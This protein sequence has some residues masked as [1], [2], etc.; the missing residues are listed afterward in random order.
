MGRGHIEKRG[1]GYAVV[2][3]L[4]KDPVTGKR[5]QKWQS[6][7]TKKDA[8]RLLAETLH[9]V[10]QGTFVE[11]STMTVAE[12]LRHWLT[13][14]EP[15]IRPSS[16]YRFTGAV[17]Q[18]FIPAFGSTPLAKLSPLQVQAAYA[19]WQ[20][21]GLSPS[22]VA[23]YHNILHRSLSQAEK[24]QRIARNVCDLVD[25]PHEVNPEMKTWSLEQARTFLETT[26]TDD[27][28]AL[29]LLAIHTGMRRGEML[30][31]RWD[32]VDFRKQT[33]AI[34]RTVTRGFDGIGFGEPKSAAGRRQ[35]AIPAVCVDAL[36]SHRARQNEQRL[37]LGTAWNDLDLVFER[38]DG[39]ILHPNIV[40]RRFKRIAADIGLPVIRFHDLRHTAATLML[41]NDE[42]PKI[43]QERL[44]HSDISMTLNRY[45]HVTMNM[46]REASDRLAAALT[47]TDR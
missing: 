31:L 43:V 28:A 33:L 10:D 1:R 5:R 7:R 30:A 29:W 18:R 14:I 16:F 3:E 35:L 19:Q 4:P 45:S 34:R 13:T 47:G 32:D 44:G 37:A 26:R 22:T 9:S 8:E 24:W 27:L 17:N 20:A 41:A 21:D 36:R 42:H 11:P 39:T 25:P 23:L 40:S 15:T 46:Q 2:V 38:G 12:Y 6:A